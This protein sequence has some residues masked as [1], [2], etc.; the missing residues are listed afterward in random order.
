MIVAFQIA[1]P[2]LEKIY[3]DLLFW[4]KRS[5]EEEYWRYTEKESLNS[6]SSS[7]KDKEEGRGQE[8]IRKSFGYMDSE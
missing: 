5:F 1:G 3:S 6:L 7:D 2:L 8:K 4:R